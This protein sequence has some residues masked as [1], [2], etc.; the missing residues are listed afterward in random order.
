MVSAI[1]EDICCEC[2]S[3]Y[4]GERWYVLWHYSWVKSECLFSSTLLVCPRYTSIW[5][6]A[7]GFNC[8]FQ[9]CLSFRGLLDLGS[10]LLRK[11]A[12]KHERGC[13]FCNIPTFHRP[14]DL[15]HTTILMMSDR[16]YVWPWNRQ[17][18]T[19]LL[20]HLRPP[21]DNNL[22]SRLCSSLQIE[23]CNLKTDDLWGWILQITIFRQQKPSIFLQN[24]M[25]CSS[26]CWSL[27]SLIKGQLK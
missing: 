24:L 14:I 15:W 25:Y 27:F 11:M 4:L 9:Y 17:G 5:G 26:N 13:F 12:R 10:F 16:G 8:F 7:Y 22:H 19:H 2:V 18:S 20:M 21:H 6:Y 3:V 23:L 1:Q